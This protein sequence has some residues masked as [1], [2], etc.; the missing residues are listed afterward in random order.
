[1]EYLECVI[2]RPLK[3]IRL[4]AIELGIQQATLVVNGNLTS[5]NN[6]DWRL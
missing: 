3:Q 1:V 5:K 6:G 4:H 2:Q